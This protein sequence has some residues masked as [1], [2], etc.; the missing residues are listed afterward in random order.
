[1]VRKEVAP[2]DVRE[3]GRAAAAR[4]LAR[5][6][7]TPRLALQVGTVLVREL[8]E[9]G[10]PERRRGVVDLVRLDGEL[11]HQDLPDPRRRVRPKLEPDDVPEPPKAQSGLES[12]QEVVGVAEEVV[13]VARERKVRISGDTENG[14]RL[15]LG[16]ADER[17]EKRYERVLHRNSHTSRAD[18]EKARDVLWDADADESG[19]GLVSDQDADVEPE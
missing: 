7:G 1:M 10:E 17:G 12:L 3:Q 8:R 6:H 15:R 16:D 9:R 5:R 11:P 13:G 19:Y 4:E 14:V 2:A 18:L